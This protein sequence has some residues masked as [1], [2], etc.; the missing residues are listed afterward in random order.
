MSILYTPDAF[1]KSNFHK[2]RSIFQRHVT[3]SP[4]TTVSIILYVLFV[5]PCTRRRRHRHRTVV[6]FIAKADHRKLS[7]AVCRKGGRVMARF[8]AVSS[9]G[10]RA[11]EPSTTMGE[12]ET[13][14]QTVTD[15]N[16]HDAM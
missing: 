14:A 6:A 9:T 11:R 3:Y 2:N 7:T 4:S 13:A 15:D 10:D 8:G 1:L 12:E 16:K 5:Q